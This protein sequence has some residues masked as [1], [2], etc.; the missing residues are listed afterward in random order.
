[1]GL[2]KLRECMTIPP[3]WAPDLPLAADGYEDKVYRKE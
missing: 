2:A 3:I 1:M